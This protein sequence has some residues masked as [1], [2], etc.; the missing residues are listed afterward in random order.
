MGQA[1]HQR[2]HDHSDAMTTQANRS[3]RVPAAGRAAG[4]R[5][6]SSS[7]PAA[8]SRR[9]QW[10]AGAAVAVLIALAV[11]FFV[12]RAA[13]PPGVAFPD[14]GNLHI[15]LPTSPHEPY[16]SDP[17]TSGPHLAY[18]APW[19]IHTEPIVKELQVHNLEDGGVVVQ[20]HCP[21]GCPA[22]VEQLKAIVQQYP[23]LVVLAPYPGMKH[24]IALTAW[25]R[26]DAFD[27]FDEA[28]IQRFIKAYRG[29][30]HHK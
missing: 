3:A 29:I 9:R 15:D 14:Q 22:L 21:S 17:P 27:D 19:G 18:V 11:G 8:T 4:T 16:N 10:I 30:D 5:N 1:H 13:E 26:M 12:Y 28:R 6:G 2:R 24:R 25:T 23:T 7:P 20:Y